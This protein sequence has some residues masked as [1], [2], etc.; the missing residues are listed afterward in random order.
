[1]VRFVLSFSCGLILVLTSV[2]PAFARWGGHS[3][4]GRSFS[5]HS[6]R[7]SSYRGD[8]HIRGHFRKNG[9]Y[10]APHY[11]SAPDGH[12]YNNW[13]T[14]RNFNPHTRKTGTR[15]TPSFHLPHY[16]SSYGYRSF[17]VPTRRY[18]GS[19]PSYR[20]SPVPS[21]AWGSSYSTPSSSFMSPFV[22]SSGP[23]RTSSP[24]AE[25]PTWTT[26]N[27]VCEGDVELRNLTREFRAGRLTLE[28]Y[29]TKKVVLE[30]QAPCP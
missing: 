7:S 26:Q 30:Q 2:P 28:A 17:G 16:S 22:S 14:R 15:V 4:R 18:Y 10:V 6:S 21:T 19:A 5:S 12:F 9:S 20:S 11:R 3:Y 27:V 13:S 1:M 24:S 8:V 29:R 25:A 23:P